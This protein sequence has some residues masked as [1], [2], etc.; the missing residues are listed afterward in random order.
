MSQEH[1]AAGIRGQ[2][3]RTT[4]LGKS[5]EGRL[6]TGIGRGGRSHLVAE[7]PRLPRRPQKGPAAQPYPGLLLQPRHHDHCGCA[8]LPHHPPEIAHG[9]RQRA[10][11]GNVGVLL[12]V[13]IDVVGVD[14][15]TPGDTY[16]QEGTR[17]NIILGPPTWSVGLFWRRRRH[18]VRRRRTRRRATRWEGAPL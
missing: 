2:P 9:L 14:V 4:A 15:V 6:P 3:R 7:Y 16:G 17:E 8:L 11:R 18:P 10:L 12:A 5:P 13:A 1:P